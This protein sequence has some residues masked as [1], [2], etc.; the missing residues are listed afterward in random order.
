MG[1]YLLDDRGVIPEAISVSAFEIVIRS[2]VWKAMRLAA[3]NADPRV[4]AWAPL[5]GNWGQATF[6]AIMT[7]P[8][9]HPRDRVLA[10][11]TPTHN[12][13]LNVVCSEWR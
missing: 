5:G 6:F 13:Q 10:K 11:K 8:S 3:H 7:G 1:A 9:D 12:A 4:P 2:Q